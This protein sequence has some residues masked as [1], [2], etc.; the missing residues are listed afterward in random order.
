MSSE[1]PRCPRCGNAFSPAQI[2]G[3]FSGI[4]PRCLAGLMQSDPGPEMPPPTDNARVPID[5]IRP[6]LQPGAVFKG[7]EILEILGQGGMGIV[8]KAR[9]QSLDR[10]VALKLLNSQLASSDEFS[11]RFD[12]EAKVLA[13][14]NHPNVVHVHDFGR[15][16]GL[17]YLVMEHV[18]GP[19]LDDAMRKKP[20][21]PARFLKAVRDVAEGLQRV[22]EVGLVHRDI[23]P[24]NVLLTR[25]GTAKISDFGLAIETEGGQKLTQSG[26]FVGTP[27]YVSPEHAQGKKV[28]GRSDLYSLGVI[29]F[30]GF[31]GRPPF[32][33]PSAT[34]ILYKHV[35]EPPPALYKLAPQSPKAV[36]EAVRKL[37][38]KNP[39]SRHDSAASLVRD[40]DR[41]LDELKTGPKPLPGTARKVPAPVPA[42]PPPA[43]FPVKWIAAGVAG[44]VVVAILIGLLSGK[45][46]PRKA[47]RE[48]DVA[49][50]VERPVAPAP[51]PPE[52][53]KPRELETTPAPVPVPVPS[54]EPPA[55]KPAEPKT[56]DALDEALKQG[57][58]LFEQAKASF[59]DGKARSSVE[60]L[61]EAGFKAEEARAKF[62][63][64]QE[65]GGD[66]LKAKGA[67]Q[68]RLAQ[69]FL[70]MV[71]ESRLA[72]QSAKGAAAAPAPAPSAPTGAS[73]EAP[74]SPSAA[75]APPTAPVRREP[76]PIAPVSS[77]PV[78]A[79]KAATDLISLIDPTQDI[80]SGAIRVEGSKLVLPGEGPYVRALLPYLP[81]AEYDLS[82]VAE[83]KSGTDSLN[84][85][86]VVGDAQAMVVLG[87]TINGD[88]SGLERIDGRNFA[89]N[90]TRTVKKVF[91]NDKRVTILC[92]VRRGAVQVSIDGRSLIQWKGDPRR[93]DVFEGWRVPNTKAFFI[94]SSGTSYH[95]HHV[96]VVPVT[97]QGFFVRKPPTP[98][99]ALPPLPRGSTELLALIDPA[100]DAVEGEW[101]VE[102]R[103]LVGAPGPHRRLQLPVLA[104]EEYDLKVTLSREDG[105]DGI[106]FGLA[107]GSAQWTVFVDKIPQEG[108]L[109]GLEMLDNGMST[110]VR[111]QQIPPGRAVTFEFKVRKGGFS[112]LKDG[113]PF[114]QWQG[115]Y[116]RL[117]N[118]S[119]WAVRNP[120]ALFLGQWET[121]IRYNE[122]KLT[123]LSGDGRLL[124]AGAA[125]GAPLPRNAVDLLA[126][127]DP[128]LDAVNGAFSKDASGLRTPNGLPW[129]RLMVP[130]APPAEYDLTMILERTENT[131]SLNLALPWNRRQ[132]PLVVDGKGPGIDDVTALD[133]IDGKEFF[134]NETTTK[135]PFLTAGKPNTLVI[136]VRR[137]SFGL[138]IDGRAI[139]T[140]KGDPSRI[141]EH[142]A[143]SVPHKDAIVI[144]CYDSGFLIS[145]LSISP[146]SGT[147]MVLRKTVPLPKNTVDL[148]ALIDSQKD[149]V[150]G[151]WTTDAQGLICSAGDHI[152]LQI[153]YSPPDEYDLHMTV[154]RREGADGLLVGLV[155]GS[156]QWA[157]TMDTQASGTFK[158]GFES[159]DNQGPSGNPTTYSG[160]VFTNGVETDLEFRVR[161]A[162]VSVVAGGKTIID[163][164]GSFNRLSLPDGW[165]VQ[166]S[167]AL[168]LAAWGSRYHFSRIVLVPV[169]GSG[170]PLRKASGSEKAVPPSG[171][172]VDL[173]KMIDPRRDAASG[174]WKVER[175]A[176]ITP[177]G[178][179]T[180]FMQIPYAPPEEYD[181][182]LD[183][184][185][186]S[187]VADL[188]IGVVAGGKQLL[189]HLDGGDGTMGGLQWIDNKD[190][191]SNE[192]TYKNSRVFVDEKPHTIL[193]AVRKN[194]LT[195]TGDGI[196]LINWK[197]DYK[198]ASSINPVGNAG[199]LFVGDWETSFE[200]SQILLTPISGQ[201]RK[202]R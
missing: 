40:L 8:Y 55:P 19:T 22:H 122:V 99:S 4:C 150:K 131:N 198:R 160:P 69:Q 103:T 163:W 98:A 202:L 114:L 119:K 68:F 58:A 39:A 177:V 95:I 34:A 51:K 37:L 173:L 47:V 185:R 120:R 73:A 135:G 63:A 106:A 200:I 72:I 184:A 148:L 24:S 158:T 9:Q 118:F 65:I 195:V 147:G 176:L 172:S 1:T 123:A 159:I 36:Q 179:S 170:T 17:L 169:S 132:I 109:S 7:F 97:G 171:A 156:T 140:W 190:W 112:V 161:K 182:R 100:Q 104:P 187:G 197:G 13:S 193:I 153:P 10:L 50:R 166:N 165:K 31:A 33:A 5:L 2:E 85:G 3:D 108:Y 25:E 136:S 186:R 43:K 141:A 124:R 16:D 188:Y 44:V 74:V 126:L 164:R 91:E 143:L 125:A 64:V 49:V 56:R 154:D 21:D 199:A 146:V 61:A 32:Q 105:D 192:T 70:K 133:F 78:P 53:E 71:N 101:S 178:R 167:K 102:N 196:P 84:L 201:G 46:E 23:K 115:N 130:Y 181:L 191:D 62:A 142:T 88:V 29:L 76:A 162:G 27:H 59:E 111:G 79:P 127:I 145:Q 66:E 94:A 149:A 138:T 137:N 30:E 28:D 155:K 48:D 15:E 26:M 90:E 117:A 81:P 183:A 14:L 144:G 93:L 110:L 151:D 194:S 11:K 6:P 75:P 52:V 189:L 116:N 168:F 87:G 92:S 129:A 57:L 174:E 77:A 134:R 121:R 18:D 128:K 41:A 139:F 38:A 67:E 60:T 83:R 80:V 42:A 107:Q 96:S 54:P 86:L 175:G 82:V 89:E 20:L 152:R 35:N 12:R 113:K 157:V 180:A 45:S